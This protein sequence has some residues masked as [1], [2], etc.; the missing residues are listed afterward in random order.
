MIPQMT[1][2]ADLTCSEVEL[3]VIPDD[4]VENRHNMCVHATQKTADTEEQNRHR[5]NNFNSN[6]LRRQ[7]ISEKFL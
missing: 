4:A 6:T 3:S 7:S 5:N 1:A 2:V